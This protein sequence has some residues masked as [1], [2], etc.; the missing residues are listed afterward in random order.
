[1]NRIIRAGAR[2]GAALVL[3]A[4]LLI[5]GSCNFFDPLNPLQRT[6]TST[7]S[8]LEVTWEKFIEGLGDD[9]GMSI[10]QTADGGYIIVGYR[11]ARPLYPND[12]DVWLIKTDSSGNLEWDK[13][14]GRSGDD[15]GACVQQTMEGGF[16]I[17][18]TT[19]SY[20]A[21]SSDIWLIKTD[22]DG[23]ESWSNTYGGV[24]YEEGT[25][26]Q[27]T[28]DGGYIVSGITESYVGPGDTSW[29]AWLVKTDG[30]GNKLWSNHFG[31]TAGDWAYCVRPTSDGYILCGSTETFGG[32]RSAYLLKTDLQGTEQWSKKYGK[33]DE[34]DRAKYL[35]VNSDGGY[36]LA[37]RTQSYGAGDWDV[38]LIKTD[39]HGNELWIDPRRTFGGTCWDEAQCVQPTEDG[40]YIIVGFSTSA[41]TS[42]GWEDVWLIKTDAS[43]QE[44][45]N[46]SFGGEAVDIGRSILQTADGGYM[47]VGETNSFAGGMNVY[48]V[49]YKP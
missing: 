37:G 34:L 7:G 2:T 36:T 28:D 11:Q 23:N 18:G 17:V 46:K 43:G 29:D 30:G 16:I 9:G 19:N 14:F 4:V 10:E 32:Y 27:Q 20:G 42:M 41:P 3:A 6:S 21:G 26:V 1:M 40:G 22:G 38:W 44:E 12:F 25:F 31:G 13:T 47:L 33:S 39:E 24:L 35:L 15:R 49:Y 45:W 48:L 5:A 8:G